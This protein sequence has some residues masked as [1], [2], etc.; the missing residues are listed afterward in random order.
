MFTF[1]T[2]IIAIC[3]I[4]GELIEFAGEPIEGISKQDAH[5][6]CQ[7]NGLG[8]LHIGEIL[9]CSKDIETGEWKDYD[10]YLN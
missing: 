2:Y 5:D 4:T 8:Y 1:S 6:Y 7:N 3:P 9:V 10:Y